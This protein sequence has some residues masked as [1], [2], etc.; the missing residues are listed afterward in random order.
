MSDAINVFGLIIPI[1]QAKADPLHP[2]FDAP[3]D[4]LFIAQ[5]LEGWCVFWPIAG[6]RMEFGISPNWAVS[7]A[8][9]IVKKHILPQGYQ[10]GEP[11]LAAFEL[12]RED[13]FD[14][15]DLNMMVE[16]YDWAT[17]QKIP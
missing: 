16:R 3:A 14:G 9:Q 2:P 11:V 4:D 8:Q 13:E 6:G 15:L 10:A 1:N 17:E 12:E 7:A 5:W